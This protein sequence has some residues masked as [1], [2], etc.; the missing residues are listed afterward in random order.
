MSFAA[1][2]PMLGGL[3]LSALSGLGGKKEKFGSTFSKGQRSLIDEVLQSVRGM[4]GNQ[5][6][7]QNQNFQT[8]QGFLQSMFND[9]EFF[10]RLGEGE[11]F[12]GV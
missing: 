3:A 2:A 5:D 6:V 1:F 4:K 10:N 8:G 11:Y 9:P 7:S 12:E